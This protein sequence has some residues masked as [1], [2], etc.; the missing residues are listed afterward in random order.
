MRVYRQSSVFVGSL[1]RRRVAVITPRCL[2][3]IAAAS[4]PCL[5]NLGH[6]VKTYSAQQ[7]SH[8]SVAARSTLAQPSS[9]MIVCSSQRR[10]FEYTYLAGVTS[11]IHGL[12]TFKV[13]Y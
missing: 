10:R 13:V 8:A 9:P 1:E 5:A 6:S 12:P 2:P 7:Y 3:S 4:V 11:S